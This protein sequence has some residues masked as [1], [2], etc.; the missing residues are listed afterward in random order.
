MVIRLDLGLEMLRARNLQ[1]SKHWGRFHKGELEGACFPVV[2][3]Y[4]VTWQ[5]GTRE[6][7]TLQVVR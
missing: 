6:S 2:Y 1:Q 4:V 3:L 7:G 5:D